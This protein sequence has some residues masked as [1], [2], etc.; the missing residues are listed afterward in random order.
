MPDKDVPDKIIEIK[1]SGEFV[2]DY[3]RT[4]PDLV[5][6]SQTCQLSPPP[7]KNTWTKHLGRMVLEERCT[8]LTFNI[9]NFP[10]N[11]MHR[12]DLN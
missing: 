7:K 6:A 1:F 4:K 8:D 12:A 2:P 5:L 11:F 9:V 3:S 10:R